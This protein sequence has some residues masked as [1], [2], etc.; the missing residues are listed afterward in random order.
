MVSPILDALVDLL[1]Q[2][3]EEQ[4]MQSWCLG[5]APRSTSERVSVMTLTRCQA[6]VVARGAPG[7]GW[8]QLP[9]GGHSTPRQAQRAPG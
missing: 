3:E 4:L 7:P 2:L 5:K 6:L 9:Q 1:A 8:P